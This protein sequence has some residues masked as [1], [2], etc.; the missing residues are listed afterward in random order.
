VIPVR[1]GRLSKHGYAVDA[2]EAMRRAALLKA[3]KEEG[4]YL[5]VF[6]Q[7]LARS[8]QLKNTSPYAAKV[9]RADA[10][11]LK[12]H[13]R[14]FDISYDVIEGKFIKGVP[15]PIDYEFTGEC[16]VRLVPE[17]NLIEV[18]VGVPENLWMEIAEITSTYSPTPERPPER[19]IFRSHKGSKVNIF[20]DN[21]G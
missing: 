15:E 13:F 1:P 5:P 6:R 21:V 2:S 10:D 18:A 14:K 9:M 12:K 8:T 20:L 16:V 7:L 4:D 17:L 3:V 19:V 11:W